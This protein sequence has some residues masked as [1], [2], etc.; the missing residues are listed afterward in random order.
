LLTQTQIDANSNCAY[1]HATTLGSHLSSE[2][3]N[4]FEMGGPAAPW[5]VGAARYTLAHPHENGALVVAVRCRLGSL[6]NEDYALL[7]TGAQWSVIG[8][9]LAETIQDDLSGAPDTIAMHTRFGRVEG[10]LRRVSITLVADHGHEL[11]VDATAF[12]PKE[13]AGPTVIG[14]GG[15]L[16]RVRF[17][18]D[19][20]MSDE[21]LYFY[22]NQTQPTGVPDLRLVT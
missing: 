20:G 15:L 11:I 6:P 14:Y 5:A 16:E 8:P 12:F 17:A 21:T 10:T 18:L 13:W 7:D 9:D 3:T 19:P 1:E 4:G 2:P 22:F